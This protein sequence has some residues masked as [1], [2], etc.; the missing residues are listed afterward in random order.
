[1]TDSGQL[2]NSVT[3]P[4]KIEKGYEIGIDC[5]H[6][7]YLELGTINMRPR[8]YLKKSINDAWEKVNK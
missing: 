5:E 8:P 1:M 2:V 4:H 7:M 6:A 3:A